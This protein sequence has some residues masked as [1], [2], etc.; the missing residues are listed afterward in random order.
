MDV[1]LKEWA[2]VVEALL[3]GR[4]AI[5]LRRGGIVEAR[6]G[7]QVRHREFLLFPTFE[8]QHASFI[9]AEHDDLFRSAMAAQGRAL[10]VEAY[11]EVVDTLAA[12][13]DAGER[14]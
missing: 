12:P 4:Q 3:A 5:L 8:H 6:N 9:R 7:F 14:S 11:A 2:V 13:A 10:R 1:A